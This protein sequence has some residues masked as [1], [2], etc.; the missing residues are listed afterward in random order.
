MNR[1]RIALLGVPLLLGS[2]AASGDVMVGD[3]TS[4]YQ[5]GLSTTCSACGVEGGGLGL[6]SDSGPYEDPVLIG[7][8]REV[9]GIALGVANPNQADIGLHASTGVSGGG[10][11][12]PYVHAI[13]DN[14]ND[15]I[16]G[17]IG[18]SSGASGRLQWY[19]AIVPKDPSPLAG[20]PISIDINFSMG[21]TASC[22]TQLT[23][24]IAEAHTYFLAAAPSIL[25]TPTIEEALDV[26]F[27]APGADS[28]L[29]P[30][31]TRTLSTYASASPIYWN[32]ILIEARG[33][34]SLTEGD[35]PVRRPSWIPRSTSRTRPM[36]PTSTSW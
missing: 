20:G 5:Y 3:K 24:C 31:T 11:T 30:P 23:S 21:A 29:F 6:E 2:I 1:I 35:M 8:S 25:Q 19:F 22:A 28:E 16:V 9:L 15:P 14:S 10:A 36:R 34:T 18:T 13:A 26:V 12:P 32:G 17:A 27:N 4:T 7:G 33:L